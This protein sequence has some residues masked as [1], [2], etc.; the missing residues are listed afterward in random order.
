MNTAMQYK[1]LTT[2]GLS[3]P[4]ILLALG[5]SPAWAQVEASYS[6]KVVCGK[7]GDDFLQV[8]AGEYATVVNIHNPNEVDVVF[9]KKAVKAQTQRQ[10]RGPISPY[11]TEVLAPDEALGVDCKDVKSLYAPPLGGYFDGFLVLRVPPDPATGV[12]PELDVWTV[13][14]AKRRDSDNSE[15]VRT[16]DVEEVHPKAIRVQDG[17]QPDLTVQLLPPATSVTCPTGQGSCEHDVNVEISE[18]NGVAVAANFQLRVVTDNGLSTSVNIAGIAAGGSVALTVTLGPGNNCY[19]P[20]CQVT[21]AVD[22]LGQVAESDE[23]N[24]TDTRL[25]LG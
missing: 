14:T 2:L 18:L 12:I 6:A 17:Q 11:V 9:R 22:N 8:L 15:D 21:A 5:G 13:H 4:L 10:P 23:G 19:N 3:L 20:D 16:I 25:D 7:A 24:N 1:G